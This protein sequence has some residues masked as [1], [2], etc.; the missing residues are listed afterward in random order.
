MSH[1]HNGIYEFNSGEITSL[2][3]G[4]AG[5]KVIGGTSRTEV[6]CGTTS[7]FE[8]IAFFIGL[9]AIE[10]EADVQAHTLVHGDDFAKH[11]S[12][13]HVY[14]TG[15]IA[16]DVTMPNGDVLYGV[17]DKITV[18]AGDYVLAYIGR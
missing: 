4:Q 8:D 16:Y 3:L 5:F 11:T 6:V 12:G 15:T 17:F 10:G 18:A 13:T 9:K 7:G 14:T 2:T 1:I